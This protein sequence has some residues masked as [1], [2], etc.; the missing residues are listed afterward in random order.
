MVVLR[1]LPLAI[2]CLIAANGCVGRQRSHDDLGQMARN[3]S[4]VHGVRFAGDIRRV[5]PGHDP[6]VFMHFDRR[7]EHTRRLRGALESAGQD[8]VELRGPYEGRLARATRLIQPV[9]EPAPARIG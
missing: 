2:A 3:A 5:V 7:A 9:M 6:A 4:P 8:Y 1:R